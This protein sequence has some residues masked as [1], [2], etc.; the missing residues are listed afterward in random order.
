ML[1][2][3]KT[4]K[5]DGSTGEGGGQIIRTALSLSM[6][7]GTPIEITNIRAGRAKSGSDASALDVCTSLAANIKCHRD[8]C[9]FGQYGV[10][11]YAKH[12]EIGRLYV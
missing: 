10:H 6:L 7:T 2:K 5:I 3:P 11:L 8:R 12:S 1:T 9:S 4:L